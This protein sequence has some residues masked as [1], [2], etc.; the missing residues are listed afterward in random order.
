MEGS[1]KKFWRVIQKIQTDNWGF[2]LSFIDN[3]LIAFQPIQIYQG[4]WTGSRNLVIYSINHEYG[5]Y[6][7]QR[8]ISVQ[9]FG[10]ICSFFCPQSYIA[11]K[12]I[13]LTKNGCTINLVKFTFDS[14]NSNYDCTLECAINF[15]D[16]EQGEL[17]ASMSDDG[18]Y[19]ITW[20]PQSREIQ[21]RR[22]NDRN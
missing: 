12:G 7:K 2:R 21:I 17:F 9:G 8:E 13:L 16:L 5:L 18:E 1:N 19:L 3:N 11:S 10:Q 15:G 6:T 22:F 20:D 14:T 4:N